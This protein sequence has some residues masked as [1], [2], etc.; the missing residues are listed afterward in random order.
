MQNITVA[1]TFWTFPSGAKIY[2]GNMTRSAD[3]INYQGKRYDFIGFDELTHFTW[4][5]YSYLYSRNRPSGKGTRVYRRATGNPGG[6]GHGWVKQY[7]VKAG[8][9]CKP[10][11]TTVDLIDNNGKLVQYSRD[12]IFVPSKVYDNKMLLDADPNYIANLALLDKADRDALLDGNWD[13]FSGQVFV[14]WKDDPAHY[15]NNDQKWTHVIDSFDIPKSWDI[16]RGFDF[17][18]ARPFSVGWYVVDHEG[19]I[20]RIKEYYGCARTPN[21]G[22]KLNPHEI[23]E[24]GEDGKINAT[25]YISQKTN[26]EIDRISA[27]KALSKSEIIERAIRLYAESN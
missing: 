23:S 21:T 5:E 24:G 18:F 11:T 14:E 3:K 19:R 27:K 4:E 6:I 16:Y 12:K 17:G 15:A 22:V 1:N 2:F 7:F 26:A 25:F 20:Y 10:I 9:P 13:S 8:E